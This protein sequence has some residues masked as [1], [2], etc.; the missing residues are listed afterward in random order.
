MSSPQ[1]GAPPQQAINELVDLLQRGL[2][3]DVRKRA[4]QLLR[5][6]PGSVMLWNLLGAASAQSGQFEAAE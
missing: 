6:Y 5:L 2:L 1:R 3:D 4:N